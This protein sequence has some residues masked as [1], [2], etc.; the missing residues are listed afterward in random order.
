MGCSMAETAREKCIL[1][2]YWAVLYVKVQKCKWANYFMWKDSWKQN[3]WAG[4]FLI[5]LSTVPSYPTSC[6]MKA[7]IFGREPQPSFLCAL[8]S[9]THRSCSSIWSLAS[10]SKH[11]H[12]RLV[13]GWAWTCLWMSMSSY[14]V[15]AGAGYWDLEY[16][17]KGWFNQPQPK[18]VIGPQDT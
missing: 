18:S 1:G 6:F 12:H 15:M 9:R 16:L 10:W 4:S 7:I 5:Q 14:I 8:S 3:S 11:R 2:S 13:V 17:H